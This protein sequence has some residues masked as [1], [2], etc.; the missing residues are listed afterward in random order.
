VTGDVLL[1]VMFC[2]VTFCRD[3]Y[4][5]GLTP[6]LKV[7]EPAQDGE[8]AGVSK[9]CDSTPLSILYIKGVNITM[10]GR[11]D[12]MARSHPLLSPY[13]SLPMRAH[14]LARI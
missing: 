11:T 10:K 2:E 9:I 8:G 3:T 14:R 1:L 5:T 6:Y 13:R 12:D 4:I 7:L